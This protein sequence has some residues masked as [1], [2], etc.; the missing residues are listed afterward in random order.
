MKKVFRISQMHCVTGRPIF[1]DCMY[2]YGL[3][4]QGAA[5]TFSPNDEDSIELML[6]AVDRHPELHVVTYLKSG[7]VVNRMQRNNAFFYVLHLGN[8]DPEIE[9]SDEFSMNDYSPEQIKMGQEILRE[10]NDPNRKASSQEVAA[11]RWMINEAVG[12]K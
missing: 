2:K 10:F 7:G 3:P 11:V 8:P 12:R 4:Y 6:A 1:G 9:F 5:G